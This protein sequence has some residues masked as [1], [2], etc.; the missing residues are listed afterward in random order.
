MRLGTNQCLQAFKQACS[1]LGLNHRDDEERLEVCIVCKA[2][3]HGW[4]RTCCY[5]FL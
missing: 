2:D 4:R 1:G 5:G 3:V